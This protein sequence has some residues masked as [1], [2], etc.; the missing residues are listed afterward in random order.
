MSIKY[1]LLFFLIFLQCGVAHQDV[2]L[3]DPFHAIT[4]KINI[5]NFTLAELKLV[6]VLKDRHHRAAFMQANSAYYFLLH[7]KECVDH[8][9]VCVLTVDEHS[10]TFINTDLQ[11]IKLILRKAVP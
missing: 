11:K 5:K 7:E 8:G 10:I 9:G 6:G 2:V 1:G 3:R 4:T